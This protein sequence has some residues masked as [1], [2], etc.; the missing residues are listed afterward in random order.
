MSEIYYREYAN[1]FWNRLISIFNIK[2]KSMKYLPIV[3]DLS[4]T[5]KSILGVTN[6]HINDELNIASIFPVVFIDAHTDEEHVFQ[7]I[8]HEIIHYFLALSYSNSR[9]GCALF[10]VLCNIFDAGA[11][12]NASQQKQQIVDIATPYLNAAIELYEIVPNEH[13]ASNISLML[14][15]INKTE[16]DGDTCDYKKL[17]L[18]LKVCLKNIRGNQQ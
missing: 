14:T 11:Y 18:Y 8:R 17:E 3:F 12:I 5:D 10:N 4:T 15:A 6:T 2:N 9:D 1:S 16:N 7:T 13:I